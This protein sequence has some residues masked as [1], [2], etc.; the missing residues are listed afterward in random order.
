MDSILAH[1]LSATTANQTGPDR[2]MGHGT[3]HGSKRH[4]DF[5]IK[6]TNDR[7]LLHCFA[8]CTLSTICESLGLQIKDLFA[9]GLASDPPRRR[10][11]AQERDRQRQEQAVAAQRQGRRI[12]ALK[13]ADYH[14][15]SR[16]EIDISGWSDQKLDEELNVLA[17]AHKLLASE[18]HDG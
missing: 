7:I 12:D 17:D 10:E 2:W 16:H 9:D 6:R 1:V 5:S 8:G 3:C 13:A 14:I 18:D 15:R 4:K 11:A